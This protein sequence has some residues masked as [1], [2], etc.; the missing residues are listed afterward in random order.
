MKRDLNQIAGKTFDLLVIG[1][2]IYGACIAWDAVLRGMSV[3]LLEKGDFGQATSANSLKTV[4]GGLRYLQKLD[5]KR[6]R[7][8][9]RERR[10]LM[11]I[12]PH[13][14]HPLACIMPVYGHGMRGRE[15]MA[16]GLWLNDLISYDRNRLMDGRKHLPEGRMLSPEACQQFLP[17][18][19]S[20]GLTG[21]AL[22]YD[23][24]MYNSE[25]LTLSFVRSAV[26]RGA[27]AANY[28][29]VTGFLVKDGRVFGVEARDGLSGASFQVRARTIVNAAG[30]WVD[31]VLSLLP[32]GSARLGIRLAKA[33]NIATR[34]I[35]KDY[36]AG[37]A[38]RPSPERSA[39]QPKIG[40]RLLFIV[41]WRNQSII[42]TTYQLHTGHP[43][44]LAVTEADVQ[45]IL[46]ETNRAYP[47]AGLT[48]EDVV[49]IYSGMVP[50]TAVDPHTGIV[51]RAGKFQIRDH[52]QDGL[53]GLISVL[54]VKYTTA[55]G[56]AEL[57]VDQ[58]FSNLGYRPPSSVSA[59][60]PLYG[61]DIQ[62]FE[63]FLLEE[64]NRRP[65]D[66]SPAMVRMLVH[67]Y[68]SAYPELFQ[69]FPQPTVPGRP[70]PEEQ[71]VLIAQIKYAVQH[72]MAMKLSDVIFRRTEQGVDG[73]PG[74]EMIRFCAQVMGNELNWDTA[75][76][77]QEIQDVERQ[78]GRE[79]MMAF[80]GVND[81]E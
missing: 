41:P 69:Y 42:G 65:C 24:Q 37:I 78:F 4:H 66:L 63:T 2:G 74:A 57:A 73:F 13:L 77:A 49:F 32:G 3:A 39:V 21:G 60:I 26:N 31:R 52:R 29:E 14:V 54:G 67:N 16:A 44:Q 61:G 19:P 56:V 23:S 7:Q 33:I 34:P 51:Q 70:V 25:R 62:A 35:I 50:V 80:S 30:P 71:A 6:M 75:R 38:A 45:E 9:T 11:R 79:A 8:S 59:Q 43:D 48:Q 64:I 12:A 55:R 46:D 81:G 27:V 15:V 40:E 53:Q 18:I 28:A 20:N 76:Q 36:A 58:V 10:N 17:G 68:G 22:W 47:P 1:G 5:I 72:E